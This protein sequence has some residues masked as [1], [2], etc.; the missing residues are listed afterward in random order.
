MGREKMTLNEMVRIEAHQKDGRYNLRQYKSKKQHHEI[1]KKLVEFADKYKFPMGVLVYIAV[2][3][4]AHRPI[5]FDKGY[6][7]FN[8]TKA[9]KVIKLC[10]IVAKQYGD[11]F[12][13]ND[14]VVHF[15]SR[16][17]D[18]KNNCETKLRQAIKDIS[19]VRFE[20]V[21]KSA[22]GAK[23]L[24]QTIFK[25]EATFTNGGYLKSVSQYPKNK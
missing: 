15:L 2:G 23:Q 18:V 25:D 22:A 5:V 10:S 24:A 6:T 3:T 13:T 11:R 4:N 8:E 17:Y 20:A 9:E 7:K 19:Q 21:L 1:C 12:Y 14:R 16:L